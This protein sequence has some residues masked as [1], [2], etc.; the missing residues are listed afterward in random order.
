MEVAA[1]RRGVAYTSALFSSRLDWATFKRVHERS[2]FVFFDTGMG[3]NFFI[4]IRFMTA[5]DL[6]RLRRLVVGAGFVRDGRRVE[7]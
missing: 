7:R 6:E 3:Q 4:P 5:A 1:D 2:G